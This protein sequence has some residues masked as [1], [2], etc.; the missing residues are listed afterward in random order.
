[1][2]NLLPE[3]V[4]VIVVILLVMLVLN[5]LVAMAAPACRLVFWGNGHNCFAPATSRL[6]RSFSWA[7]LTTYAACSL[8]VEEGQAVDLKISVISADRMP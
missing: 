4:F 2:L 1:M 3:S 8:C 6:A 5:S 7:L